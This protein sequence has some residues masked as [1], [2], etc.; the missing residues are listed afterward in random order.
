MKSSDARMIVEHMID[1]NLA[2]QSF[3]LPADSD[4][5]DIFRVPKGPATL[6][7][8]QTPGRR[9]IDFHKRM[10][11]VYLAKADDVVPP[12]CKYVADRI[13]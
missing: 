3:E 6:V 7:I 12:G 8:R 5:V 10:C 9:S 4:I 13:P 11:V 1:Y 2:V